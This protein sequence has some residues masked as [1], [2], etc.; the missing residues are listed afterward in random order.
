MEKSAQPIFPLLK[1]IRL[2]AFGGMHD[3]LCPCRSPRQTLGGLAGIR[4]P[5][6]MKQGVPTRSRRTVRG[7]TVVQPKAE[8]AQVFIHA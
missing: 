6:E 1:T 8:N 3:K 4:K 2:P 5:R 7:W